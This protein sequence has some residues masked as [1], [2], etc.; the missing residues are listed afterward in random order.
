MAQHN[1]SC[2]NRDVDV[3]PNIAMGYY[4]KEE[5]EDE[6]VYEAITE[7]ISNYD[8]LPGNDIVNEVIAVEVSAED[9]LDIKNIAQGN[10][11]RCLMGT[12]MHQEE[13]VDGIKIEPV[14][15]NPSNNE[16]ILQETKYEESALDDGVVDNDVAEHSTHQIVQTEYTANEKIII[17]REDGPYEQKIKYECEICGEAHLFENS[18]LQHMKVKHKLP[19]LDGSQYASK[20]FIKVSTKH[21]FT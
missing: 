13:N 1:L 3:K 10:Q 6:S 20:I 19:Y 9:V 4:T 14:E 2:F 12:L 21:H 5:E 16:E 8:R 17:Y 18:F 7:A 11:V 15:E